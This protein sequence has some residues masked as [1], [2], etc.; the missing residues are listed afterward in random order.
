MSAGPGVIRN[1]AG[2]RID[3]TFTPAAGPP[4][5]VTPSKV[6]I[7]AHGVTA[8]KERPL[9][10]TL[11]D[12]LA[13]AGLASLRMS[14]AG[15]GGSEG[16]FLDAVPSKEVGDLRAVVD[17]LQSWGGERIA[18]AGHSMGG[19]VGVLTASREPRI[20]L[21]VSLAG[22]VHVRW[23]F[24][25]HFAHLAYGA[26]MLDKPE[27]PWGPAL[28]EDARRIDSVTPQAAAIAVPW[29][30]VHGDAD[31]LVRYQDSLDAVAAADGRPTLVTLPGVDH[32]FNG[33]LPQ[34]ADAVVAWLAE[35]L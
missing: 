29:L 28:L 31:E 24:E 14:F 8:H 6:V 18:Y 19:A 10:V 4:A 25:T 7:L 21:L 13:A 3:Y 23:F 5:E 12:A 20:D 34:V 30:L 22:M 11:A 15:N 35:R 32:R 33:A 2:E 26:P 1:P 9:L 17:A 16:R 27:C